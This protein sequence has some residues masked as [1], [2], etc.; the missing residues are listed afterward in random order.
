MLL[1]TAGA[2]GRPRH[3]W[4]YDQCVDEIQLDNPG[5]FALERRVDRCQGALKLVFD[6]LQRPEQLRF[7][8]S[9][10]VAWIQTARFGTLQL[11]DPEED[12]L[13]PLQE[14]TILWA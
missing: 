13:L 2:L 8:R 9:G 11:N 3:D 1:G 4:Y 12:G 5:Q 10:H 6:F 7:A 14:P